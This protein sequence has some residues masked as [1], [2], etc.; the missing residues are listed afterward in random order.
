MR[1]K[2]KIGSADISLS[3]DDNKDFNWMINFDILTLLLSALTD[4]DSE[5]EVVS[6]EVASASKRTFKALLK[7]CFWSEDSQRQQVLKICQEAILK[8]L[9]QEV[10]MNSPSFWRSV[11]DQVLKIMKTEVLINVSST[12]RLEDSEDQVPASLKTKVLMNV[13]RLY[14]L[15]VLKISANVRWFWSSFAEVQ[16]NQ[17]SKKKVQETC[18]QYSGLSIRTRQSLSNSAKALCA[19]E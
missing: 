7:T 10:L 4:S 9:R 13:S 6:S 5:A 2:N 1:C 16:I 14:G 8:T 15:K 18:T 11:S 17:K 19:V 3:F 12:Q